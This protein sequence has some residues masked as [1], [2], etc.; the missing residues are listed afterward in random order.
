M[1]NLELMSQPLFLYCPKCDEVFELPANAK[2]C[3]KCREKLW[4]SLGAFDG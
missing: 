4:L 3:P 1:I 2:V